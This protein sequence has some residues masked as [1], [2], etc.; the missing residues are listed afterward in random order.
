MMLSRRVPGSGVAR[1][2]FSRGA[3][4]G[5]GLGFRRGALKCWADKPPPPPPPPPKKKSSPKKGPH[6]LAEQADKASKKKKK[7]R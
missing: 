5:G 3:L 7:K 4:G 2:F 6:F 1:I